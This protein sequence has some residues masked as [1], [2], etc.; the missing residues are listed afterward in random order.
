MAPFLLGACQSTTTSTTTTAAAPTP[1]TTVATQGTG[2]A[3]WSGMTGPFP[4]NITASATSDGF[5]ANPTNDA[6]FAT[7]INSVRTN[8]GVTPLT[9]NAQLDTAAQ[10]HS[11][12]MLAN[13]FLGHTGSNGSTIRQRIL[14]AGYTPTAWGENVAQG[15]ENENRAMNGWVSS[16][17]HQANNISPNFEHFGLGRAGS[18]SNT[19]WTL[20]FGAD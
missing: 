9:Y 13:N 3:D 19:R 10:A 18:G 4:P 16:A 15:Q 7:L 6:S 14:A 20:V 1:A 12:D 5:Q 8:A 2:A 17:P 11:N